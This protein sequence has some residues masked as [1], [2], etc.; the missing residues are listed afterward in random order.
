MEQNL[1]S[2]RAAAFVIDLLIISMLINIPYI[3][4]FMF[5]QGADTHFWEILLSALML[6]AMLCKDV[7]D[8][9]SIGKRLMKIQVIDEKS[10]EKVSVAKSVIG[11]S[12]CQFGS[13]KLLY[14]YSRKKN[15]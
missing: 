10:G 12:L 1:F 3:F 6:T 4:I 8:G 15:E 14:F 2:K 9:Q 7:V 5:I 13:S 11:I